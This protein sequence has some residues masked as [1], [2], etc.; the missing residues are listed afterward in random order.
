MTIQN[1]RT[2]NRETI[3]AIDRLIS[4][5]SVPTGQG[6]RVARFLLAWWNSDEWG[7]FC[8]LDL[9]GVDTELSHA[10]L[11]AMA[12][13]AKRGGYPDD[14]GY[15]DQLN[16]LCILWSHLKRGSE[17]EEQ[18]MKV[19]AASLAI[20]R[21]NRERANTTGGAPRRRIDMMGMPPPVPRPMAK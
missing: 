11:T 5:A 8:P 7:G 12:H 19:A 15:G 6:E 13:L 10:M 4:V 17:T 2:L 1:P 20:Q 16:E 21:R 9:R 3:C 14:Y 18:K